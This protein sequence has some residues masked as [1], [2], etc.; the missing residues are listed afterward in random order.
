MRPQ[1][2]N[3]F[4]FTCHDTSASLSTGYIS[5]ASWN[6]STGFDHKTYYPT[7]DSGHNKST[8]SL[9]MAQNPAVPSKENI[10]CKGCHSEHGTT[11]DKLIA[12]QVN[13]QAVVFKSGSADDYN[14]YY[15][16]FCVGCHVDAGLGG[17]YW[18]GSIAYSASGHGASTTA[19]DP[20]VCPQRHR[21]EPAAAGEALQAVPRT[22]R[23]GRC[24]Q[25]AGVSEPDAAL[26]GERVLPLSRHRVQPGGCEELQTVVRLCE[27]PRSRHE[28]ERRPQARPG[29]GGSE[30][31]ER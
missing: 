22:P 10:A 24:R 5:T 20:G 23:R 28:H 12:E 18:P 27:Q 19:Q 13:G 31:R 16:P 17:S 8:G 30:A 3:A 2:G 29:C 1:T 9:V 14:T 7:D 26:R 15:N 21:G 6:T 4:C 25:S 11:N